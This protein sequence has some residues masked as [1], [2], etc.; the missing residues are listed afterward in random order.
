MVLFS[1][2]VRVHLCVSR[3][4]F[5]GELENLE[6]GNVSCSGKGVSS[7]FSYVAGEIMAE[8]ERPDFSFCA[9]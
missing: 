8:I 2:S 1:L 4:R 6:S 5:L 9:V 3:G 7:W